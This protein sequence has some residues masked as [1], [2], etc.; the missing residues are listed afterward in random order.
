MS[1]EDECI[2]SLMKKFAAKNQKLAQGSQQRPVNGKSQP[3]QSPQAQKAQQTSGP[4]EQASLMDDAEASNCDKLRAAYSEL[5]QRHNELVDYI[6]TMSRE[7]V[8]ESYLETIKNDNVLLYQVNQDLR[9]IVKDLCIKINDLKNEKVK[10]G[11]PMTFAV[12][13]DAIEPQRAQSIKNGREQQRLMEVKDTE[14]E[15]LNHRLAILEENRQDL[16]KKLKEALNAPKFKAEV[17]GEADRLNKSLRQAS[18]GFEELQ[19]INKNL[20]TINKQKQNELE[21]H[22]ERLASVTSQAA[23]KERTLSLELE[24]RKSDTERLASE[25]ELLKKGI[26]DLQLKQNNFDKEMVEKQ[27][28]VEQLLRLKKDGEDGRRQLTEIDS[29]MQKWRDQFYNV[30]LEKQKLESVNAEINAKVKA[31]EAKLQSSEYSF[32]QKLSQA[33]SKDSDFE[34]LKR[35]NSELTAQLDDCRREMMGL[36][37][38]ISEQT[39][40]LDILKREGRERDRSVSVTRSHVPRP[41]INP[42]MDGITTPQHTTREENISM[43]HDRL[44]SDLS[45]EYR[46]APGTPTPKTYAFP[47]NDPMGQ[48]VQQVNIPQ[49]NTQ[50]QPFSDIK[51]TS[52]AHIPDVLTSPVNIEGN[53]LDLNLWSE[54][55]KLLTKINYLE[56]SNRQYERD[57]DL[58]KKELQ[59]RKEDSE[60][61]SRGRSIDVFANRE[62]REFTNSINAAI[63]RHEIMVQPIQMS[64]EYVMKELELAKAE[65]ERLKNQIVEITRIN[66]NNVDEITRLTQRIN[67]LNNLMYQRN[68]MK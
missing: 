24:Q 30:S 38:R 40:Q 39:E 57:I 20:E 9:L 65:N 44:Y 64:H 14:I 54:N 55:S 27:L 32:A 59:K 35:K 29:E 33:T 56:S 25:N 60:R 53:G 4:Q 63:G 7:Q 68:S 66:H 61:C 43:R 26:I 52:N 42:K 48:P 47:Q 10:L 37:A 23:Q 67:E 49:T 8:T 45:E 46:R 22:S 41:T 5:L 11:R 50:Y 15:Q 28:L 1:N 58:L 13:G 31:L 18:K 36:R 16:E 17:S 62:V 6:A 3:F 21:M 2:E 34:N 12:E 19:T 51:I